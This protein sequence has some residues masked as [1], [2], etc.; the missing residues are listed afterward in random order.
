MDLMLLIGQSNAKGCGNPEKSVFAGEHAWEYTE[1]ISGCAVIPLGPTLQLSDGRGTVAPAFAKKYHEV[2]GND[3][4]VIHYAV[5][6][7]RIKNWLHDGNHF[8]E[9][10]IGKCN[11]AA[12]YIAQ[13]EEIGR[14]F[15]VWIQGESDGKY[16]SEPLYYIAQ[17]KAIRQTLED[18]CGIWKSL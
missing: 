5:D 13:K 7:S 10:A 2:T 16:A 11:R 18:R 14:K 4:C 15:A 6:G 9:E 17:L 3:V 1:S 8:L 12:E